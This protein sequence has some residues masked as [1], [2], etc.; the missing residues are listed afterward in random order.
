MA[1]YKTIDQ[2]DFF[3]HMPSEKVVLSSHS[4]HTFYIKHILQLSMPHESYF[5]T[6]KLKELGQIQVP[7]TGISTRVINSYKMDITWNKVIRCTVRMV[8]T[9]SSCNQME[10]SLFMVT[11]LML[12]TMLYGLLIQKEKVAPL[13]NLICKP[14]ETWLFMIEL[15]AQLGVQAQLEKESS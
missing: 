6:S 15:T 10:T 11:V 12:V 3:K 13:I 4:K 9:I 1:T 14:T 5:S 7:S 8:N 2:I